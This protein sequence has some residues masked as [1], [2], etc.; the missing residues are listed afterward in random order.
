[1]TFHVPQQYRI[2]LSTGA[3]V[4][5]NSGEFY[6][7][8]RSPRDRLF[9]IASDGLDWEHVSVS[10]KYECPSW[11][12]MCKVKALFWDEDDCVIQY[13]PPKNVAINL[14]SYCLH[15]WRPIGKEVPLPPI[16][17]V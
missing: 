5:A 9:V 14:H 2:G 4:N 3:A 17:M 8:G 15:L 6:I 1:M 16:F 12:E 10:K 13:H 7:P 11:N